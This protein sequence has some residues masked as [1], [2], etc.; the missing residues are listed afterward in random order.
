MS[1]N[2]TKHI[3]TDGTAFWKVPLTGKMEGQFAEVDDNDYHE[4]LRLGIP[5][6]WHG[7]KTGN[8]YGPY[9]GISVPGGNDIGVTQVPVA[10]II[11]NAGKGEI[12]RYRSTNK[13][14]LRRANIYL[15]KGHRKES[16][17]SIFMRGEHARKLKADNINEAPAKVVAHG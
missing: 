10:G 15:G 17:L 11:L 3:D 2:P 8:K 5:L 12:V 6:R 1:N 7:I 13:L 14:N 4:M 16:G 9:V